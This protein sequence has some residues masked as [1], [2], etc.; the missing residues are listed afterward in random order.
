LRQKQIQLVNLP[1]YV[2]YQYVICLVRAAPDNN[3]I[4]HNNLMLQRD[5]RIF[6]PD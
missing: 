6:F 5:A 4:I 3:R 1:K 2:N